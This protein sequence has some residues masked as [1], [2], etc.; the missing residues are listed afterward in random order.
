MIFV[1]TEHREGKLKPITNELL[2]FAQR[3]AREFAQPVTTVVQGDNLSAI[4]D[5]L[6]T[7]RSTGSSLSRIP[8]SPTT[9]P[10]LTSRR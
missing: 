8:V 1:L 10:I 3:V 2:V 6:K 9:I 4:T 7:K 5:E